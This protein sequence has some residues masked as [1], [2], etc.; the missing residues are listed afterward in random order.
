M[1]QISRQVPIGFP[2]PQLEHNLCLKIGG[3]FG[4]MSTFCQTMIKFEKNTYTPGE[5]ITVR[6]ICDNSMCDKS[7]KSFK[8]KLKRKFWVTL[9]L[10]LG[11]DSELHDS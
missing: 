6:F 2:T 5:K 4:I 11:S 9:K 3:T 10:G 7:V 1:I 8:L